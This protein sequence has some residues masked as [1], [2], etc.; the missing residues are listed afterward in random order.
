[1]VKKAWKLAKGKYA[2]V[3]AR[4]KRGIK[5]SMNAARSA[6]GIVA[7]STRKSSK[8][9]TKRKNRRNT[10]RRNKRVA[11][12]NFKIPLAVVA[13]LASSPGLRT[14]VEAVLQGNWSKA[15][16]NIGRLIGVRTDGRFSMN[17]LVQ[18]A[19]PIV[20]GALISKYVGGPP[21]NLNRKLAGIPLI[22]L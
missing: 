10:S 8:K 16:N 9:K 11:R 1:M 13:G 7:G 6:A 2:Y 15:M 5:S 14:S 22:K 21:L 20:I 12:R 19:G 17:E 4:G 3:T 18:N